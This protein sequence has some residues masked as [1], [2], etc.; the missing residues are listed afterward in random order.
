MCTGKGRGCSPLT[1]IVSFHYLL[2]PSSR[3]GISAEALTC[4]PY[5]QVGTRVKGEV[6][7]I[8]VSIFSCTL[9][10]LAEET[11]HLNVELKCAVVEGQL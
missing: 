5:Y 3:D 6:H 8:A 11:A 4:K 2:T 10:N 9:R 7:E 1:L